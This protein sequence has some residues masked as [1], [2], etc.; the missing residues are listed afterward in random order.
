MSITG[1]AG[2]RP[3]QGRRARS[4]TWSCAL[5][6]ALG[7]TRRAAGSA[8][9]RARASTSTSRCWSPASRSRSGRP[10]STSPPARSAAPLGSA[11][12]STAPYQAVRTAD[13]YVTVGAVTPKTWQGFCDALG[14]DE[15]LDD[16]RYADA[17][18]PPR[19]PRHALIPAI[20]EVTTTPS[21][22]AR[23]S[24][25]LDAAG[26]PC[27]PIADYGQ[28]FTDDH[29]DQRDYFWDAAAPDARPG[30]P[31]RLADAAVPDTPVRRRTPPARRS[32]GHTVAV[33]RGGRLPRCARSTRCSSRA[34]VA[35]DSG[36]AHGAAPGAVDPRLTDPTDPPPSK[37][38]T[39][40]TSTLAPGATGILERTV[41][42]GALHPPRRVRH[43]LH[44]Q[45]GAAPRGGRDRGP[46]AA[47]AG[48][49]GQRRQPG[50]GRPH[51]PDPAGPDR[52]RPP[53]PSPRSTAGASRFD[54]R[55]RGRRG[56]SATARTSGSSS[57]SPRSRS[58]SPQKAE[59]L[60]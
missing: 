33:L 50:R 11:H 12:Q 15:L 38:R 16:E 14:L 17:S 44:A 29:L 3:G 13:G 2:R 4:A 25:L 45:P 10:A 46:R 49:P 9:R 19:P 59:Q 42:D 18:T 27:A 24:T 35:A 56:R 58:G 32:G 48:G 21:R 26:V 36:S 1:T 30:P 31:A 6:V 41:D 39:T 34:V 47:P 37:R 60:G 53:R 57:T 55:R 51:R 7:V 28:V 8:S 23:S 22:P 20:E 40:M 54:H 52:S 43:L 5:Y